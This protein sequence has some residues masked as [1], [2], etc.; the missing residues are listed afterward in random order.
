MSHR[1][2]LKLAN[3]FA[4]KTVMFNKQIQ[5]EKN[6]DDFLKEF[7][8]K[9]RSILNEMEGD[10]LA[11]RIKGI[12]KASLMAF[13]KLYKELLEIFKTFHDNLSEQDIQKIIN[14][15][16]N[17]HNRI[18]IKTLNDA[19]QQFLS[20]NQETFHPSMTFKPLRVDSLHKLRDLIVETR[21]FII[22]KPALPTEE[23]IQNEEQNPDQSDKS[24]VTRLDKN[25]T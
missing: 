19:I 25:K 18:I 9:F 1:K 7:S 24:A 14:Y 22:N 6:A 10:Q 23:S 21:S 3:K 8:R 12:N 20:E 16:F 13:N 5:S 11:L 17:K 2:I 15:V 4:L